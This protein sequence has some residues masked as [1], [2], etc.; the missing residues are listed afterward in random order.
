[1]S[2]ALLYSLLNPSF[3][4][5]ANRFLVMYTSH[6]SLPLLLQ[7]FRLLLTDL[8]ALDKDCVAYA[9]TAFGSSIMNSVF[10]FFYVKVFL[11]HYAVSQ[12]WFQLSLTIFLLWNAINDPLFGYFLDNS[13][14]R[15]FKSRRLAIMFGA[16]IYVVA[17]LA[18][19]VPWGPGGSWLEGVHLCLTLCFYD[20]CLTFVLLAH[21]CLIAEMS[22]T[23]EQRLRM[24]WYG[25]IASG[26]LSTWAVPLANYVSDN[27]T[28]FHH[29]QAAC[30]IIGLIA[31]VAMAYTGRNAFTVYDRGQ[32]VEEGRKTNAEGEMKGRHGSVIELTKQIL[33]E[34]DFQAFVWTNFSQIFHATYLSNFTAIVVDSFVDL[35]SLGKSVYFACLFVFPS[36]SPA[37]HRTAPP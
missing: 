25:V 14:W 31:Y 2:F 10:M 26:L 5:I 32:H 16:P 36:V 6:H 19:W 15:C 30:L 35:T 13:N 33:K 4:G 18:F 7:R 22:V 21:C 1:M 12:S 23:Y 3:Y 29:F 17:F 20:A 37:P 24:K 8:M 28:R 11:T 27:L 9:A 34:R